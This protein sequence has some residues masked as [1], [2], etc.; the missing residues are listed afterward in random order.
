MKTVL[1]TGGTRRLGLAIASRLRTDGWRVLTTSHR[2][3]SGADIVADLSKPSGA[4]ALYAEALHILGG[5]PPDALVN[6]AAILSGGDDE[7]KNVNLESPK[8]LTILMAGR[9][10][11]RGAV[12]NILDADILSQSQD[13]SPSPYKA[14]KRELLEFTSKS[15]VMFAET[16]RVNAVAPGPVMA[17]ESMHMKAGENLIGRPTAE[18]V[19]DAVAFL[20][21]ASSTTGCTIPVD[22]GQHLVA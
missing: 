16:L 14:A 4:A 5:T 2:A 20:L 22:G 12:V 13:A 21:S 9:E 8:K 17:P 18:A 19:A 1:V 3:D 7:I 10:H 15:A 11:G 6:N